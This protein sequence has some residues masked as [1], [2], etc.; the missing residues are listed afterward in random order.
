MGSW[1]RVLAVLAAIAFSA[2]CAHRRALTP[3]APVRPTATSEPVWVVADPGIR[4]A[5]E[6]CRLETSQP[7]QWV[8]LAGYTEVGW[9]DTQFTRPDHDGL[10][11]PW[12][13]RAELW[14]P[15][16][17]TE[18]SWGPYARFAGVDSDQPEAFENVQQYGVGF[19][20]YPF[21]RGNIRK[22]VHSTWEAITGPLRVFFERNWQHF[23]G[24]G[25]EWRPRTLNRGG[26]EYYKAL[27]V[28]ETTQRR[29][30]EFYGQAIWQS[31]NDFDV[32]YRTWVFGG[33]VRAGV[34]LADCGFLAAVSPYAVVE[35]SRTRNDAYWWENRALLG[36]GIRFDPDLRRLPRAMDWLTRFVVFAEYVHAVGYFGAEPPDTIP[37]HDLR[38]GLSFA[39][40]D[41]FR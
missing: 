41:F 22:E 21:S 38:I 17:K 20:V 37:D 18:F 7:S 1:I 10:F 3:P 33:A 2:G 16:K 8:T 24:F 15:P 39:V 31:S 12:E 25:N 26:L 11:I 4:L 40:G 6:S 36:A 14:L 35:A 9:R 34:R 28:N 13:Y 32:N 19:Q 27:H 5:K 23:S 29:W 30:A